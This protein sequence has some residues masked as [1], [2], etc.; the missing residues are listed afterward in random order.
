MAGSYF[1]LITNRIELSALQSIILYAYRWQIELFFKY[2]KRTL[3]G[4]H[5]F[6]QSE[7]GVEIQFYLLMT[8]SLLRLKFKQQTEPKK[9]R[10]P[11]K[12]EKGEANP[13]EWIKKISEYFMKVGKLARDGY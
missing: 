2:L 9:K 4:L 10:K 13:S 8:F 1:R 7:N 5:L 3:N 6:N 11:E 12:V